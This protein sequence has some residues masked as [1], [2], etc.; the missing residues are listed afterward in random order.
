MILLDEFGP[1]DV[2]F[3][4]LFKF[5]SA[6]LEV[7]CTCAER[8]TPR[9]PAL[10]VRLNA[11]AIEQNGQRYTIEEGRPRP[12]FLFAGDHIANRVREYRL[13]GLRLHPPAADPLVEQ[14]RPRNKHAQQR[15]HAGPEQSPA[16]NL[17][18]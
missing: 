8:S 5:Q 7:V 12:L 1:L 17:F 15:K 13:G 2:P 14:S 11:G 4:Q 9:T 3:G 18:D 10:W 6:T 16:N